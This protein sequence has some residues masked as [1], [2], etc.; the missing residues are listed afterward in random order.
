MQ[1]LF[2]FL[3]MIAF[4]VAYKFSDIFTATM[5]IIVVV[6]LQTAYQWLRHR[7]V[8][9]TMLISGVLVLIFGGLTLLIHDKTFIQWKPTVL[10]WLFAIALLASPLL[11]DRPLLQK[12]MGENVSLAPALWSRLNASWAIFFA[13]LGALNLYV[14]YTYDEHVWVNFKVFGATALLIVFALGQSLWL[15]NKMPAEERQ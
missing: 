10:Y 5:V 3:P 1:L 4:F 8:S 13:I 14:A 11:G 9:P 6:I 15:A 2:D 12:M 7:K